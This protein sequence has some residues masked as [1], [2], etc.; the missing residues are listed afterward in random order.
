MSPIV[1]IVVPVYGT[2]QYL[3][4]CLASLLR[5]SFSDIEVL[6]VDDR[7]PGDP[8]AVIA[9]VVGVDPRVRL[10]RHEVNRG[11]M[12]ARFTGAS[13][14]RGIYLAFVDSDD[15]VE[16][17]YI[18]RLYETAVRHDAD[19]VQGAL[20]LHYPHV[21]IVNR[22]GAAHELRG[23]EVLHGMLAGEMMVNVCGKLIRS[24]TWRVAVEPLMQIPE[25]LDFAED[26]LC[27]V[28]VAM[29]SAAYAHIPDAGYHYLLRA[30]GTTLADEADALVRNL[31]SLDCVY[32]VIR[33]SL[34]TRDEPPALVKAFFDLEFRDVARELLSRLA[35]KVHDGPA[36]LP[37]SP[38]ALGLMGAVAM[39]AVGA[40]T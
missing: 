29:H 4:D 34:A 26:L 9:A 24:E 22:G 6:V 36:G 38:A 23:A 28:S 20:Q 39:A 18:E 35:T 3:A 30:S 32:R 13:N 14:A 5:Q 27:T 2:E 12:H 19:L 37:P 25:R 11:V 10:I 40:R 33:D 31:R 15:E 8:G 16:D 7:S 21:R 17:W 1:S